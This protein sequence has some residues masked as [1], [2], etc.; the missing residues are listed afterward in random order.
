MNPSTKYVDRNTREA[1]TYL[2]VRGLPLTQPQLY[3]LV[4]AGHLPCYRNS[5]KAPLNF[6]E[7]DLQ[8]LLKRRG[9]DTMTA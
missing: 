9:F 3:R 7:S 4:A 8:E 1:L 6:R 5:P 2:H